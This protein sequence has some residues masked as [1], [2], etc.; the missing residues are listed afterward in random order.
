VT[1]RRRRGHELKHAILQT[2]RAELAEHGYAGLTYEKVAAAASTSKAV[3]YRRWPTK[4]GMVVAA[5][6][7]DDAEP[8]LRPPDTG[9]LATDLTMLLR[10][11]R[12]RMQSQD[13]ET[14]LNLL[15]TLDQATAESV[16]EFLLALNAELLEPVLEHARRRGELGAAA[17]P[18]RVLALPFDLLRHD[19]LIKGSLCSNDDVDAIV[20]D[21]V[22]PLFATLSQ[23][24][25]GP[26]MGQCDHDERSTG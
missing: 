4:A 18:E 19:M 12:H 25:A 24:G 7:D 6:A 21:C 3:L 1:A 13:R 5:L 9:S 17:I 26:E 20:N 23:A 22:L 15:A 11:A 10:S 2:V 16:R 8:F 14:T